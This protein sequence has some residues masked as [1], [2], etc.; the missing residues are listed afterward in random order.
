M[1]ERAGRAALLHAI[2][3]GACAAGCAGG[4]SSAP[5]PAEAAAARPV[6]ESVR[7]VR[8]D[9]RAAAARRAWLERQ[10]AARSRVPSA[11]DA[12]AADAESVP[13]KLLIFSSV[14][15]HVP[16]G[17]VRRSQA[18]TPE[19]R[20]NERVAELERALE[21]ERAREE[22]PRE[23]GA[24]VAARPPEPAGLDS[25]VLSAPAA[26]PLP[27]L[28]AARLASETTS[29]PAGSWGNA[30]DLPV[31][32]RSLDQDGNGRPEEVRY[33]DVRTQALLRREED[34]DL[35]G[36]SDAWSRYE[37]GLLLERVLDT[38]ADGRPDEWATYENDRMTSR[39]IDVDSDGRRETQYRYRNDTLAEIRRDTD[40]D[41]AIDRVE[42]F[43][44][45]RRVRVVED[46]DRDERMDIWTTYGVVGGA[47]VVE[48]IERDTTGSGKPNVFE[49]YRARP[50]K[51]V[52]ER[53]EEDLDGDGVI[54]V[55][56][57]FEPDGSPIPEPTAPL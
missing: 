48:R 20:E 57:Q 43:E 45:R 51:P 47:E 27:E 36:N 2:V 6:L 35:D 15:G 3:T 7:P 34:R 17:D 9:E 8:A 30:E 39:E 49:T 22:R 24:D 21:A 13:G 16:V 46:T 37:R 29:L 32:R 40:G 44:L 12:P 53:R 31:V 33:F 5:A 28:D 10:A 23:A 11:A 56:Q 52:L 38:N 41:G 54:D 55:T 18:R 4:P 25:D 14:T 1:F 19:E 26:P 42:I 50:G